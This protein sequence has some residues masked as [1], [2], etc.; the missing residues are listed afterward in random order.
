[1]VGTSSEVHSPAGERVRIRGFGMWGTGDV[2][3]WGCGVLGMGYWVCGVL[4]MLGTGDE[5]HWG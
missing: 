3:Y 5:E 4:G 1:M 2:G